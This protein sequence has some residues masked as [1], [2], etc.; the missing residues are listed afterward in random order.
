MTATVDA[1]VDRVCRGNRN[2]GTLRWV[3]ASSIAVTV[4]VVAVR[5]AGTDD[6]VPISCVRFLAPFW[7]CWR[8]AVCS[9]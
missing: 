9:T 8:T 6:A 1:A 3:W 2:G 4:V 7:A 5:L